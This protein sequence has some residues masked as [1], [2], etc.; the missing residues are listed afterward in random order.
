MKSRI[1]WSLAGLLLAAALTLP[2]ALAAQDGPACLNDSEC[3]VGEFCARPIGKCDNP[4]KCAWRPEGCLA[5]YDPV[6]GCDGQTY[7]N[8]CYAAMAGMS[9]AAV[10]ACEDQLCTRNNDCA[11]GFFCLHPEGDCDGVGLCS[12]QPEYCTM[13]YAPVCGCDGRT[14]GNA[15]LAASA[16]V[17]VASP[18]VCPGDECVTNFDC[19]D[20][21]FC[22]KP[23]Q[24]C[25]DRGH[26]EA[27]PLFCPRVLDPVC[28]CDGQ[29]YTNACYAA[30][31]GVSVD[32]RG[33]TCP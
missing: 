24:S 15:C 10:G 31:A 11:D 8:A 5:V 27:L 21:T 2:A 29:V 32:S 30:W 25:N 18:G 4:G 14:Y 28:G 1:P 6:C 20:G 3:T 9:I 33:D 12:L 7:G 13:I 16:G 22:Q 23:G 26:C 19:P 17:S